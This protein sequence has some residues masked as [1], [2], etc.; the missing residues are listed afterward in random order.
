MYCN[1][2]DMY[3]LTLSP[4]PSRLMVMDEDDDYRSRF[5]HRQVDRLSIALIEAANEY[6]E[7]EGLRDE[8]VLGALATA[9][10]RMIGGVARQRQEGSPADQLASAARYLRRVAKLEYHRFAGTQ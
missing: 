3:K 2:Y 6:A 7:A 4:P 1:S 10:G 8:V 9:L 5:E